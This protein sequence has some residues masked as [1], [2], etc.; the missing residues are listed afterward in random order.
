LNQ[1]LIQSYLPFC[2]PLVDPIIVHFKRRASKKVV[3]TTAHGPWWTGI[4]CISAGLTVD[5]LIKWEKEE[6]L[7]SRGK[8]L[9]PVDI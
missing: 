9:E 3:Y 1:D 2:T 8:R 6:E 4:E 7:R 5:W